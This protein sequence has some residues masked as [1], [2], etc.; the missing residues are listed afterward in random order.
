M[1]VTLLSGQAQ[2]KPNFSGE[3]KLN[4][5]KSEFGPMPAPTSRTD[6]ITHADPSLKITTKQSTPNG[7]AT[8]DMKYMTDGSES[9]NEI[10][11]NPMKSVSKWD[12]DTLLIDTK[13]S[14][15]G[16]D[17]TIGDKWTLSEDGKVLT[18]NR[19]LKAPQGELDQK[20]VFEKQ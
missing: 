2:A 17:I 3:W 5:T 15:Q 12:G 11:G 14:F 8:V 16:N 6:T 10:R 19:H 1:A 13:A 18:V 9:T 7:D 4:T 20:M